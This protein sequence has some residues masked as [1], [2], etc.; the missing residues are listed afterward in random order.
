MKGIIFSKTAKHKEW[1]KPGMKF[2]ET[3]DILEWGVGFRIENEKYIPSDMDPLI[4][5]I[6]VESYVRYIVKIVEII[7]LKK[8]EKKVYINKREN[9]QEYINLG[10]R[11][12][13][14]FRFNSLQ[15]IKPIKTINFIKTNGENVKHPPQS[16]VEVKFNLRDIIVKNK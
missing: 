11:H 7:S 2:L 13:T 10:Y 3:N 9:P 8:G 12:P 6:N 15:K 16:Y 4:G 14:F 1:I 5:F